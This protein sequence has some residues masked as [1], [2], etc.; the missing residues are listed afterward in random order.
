MI[1]SDRQDSK[2]VESCPH[3]R[4]RLG[5]AQ[6]SVARSTHSSSRGSLPR[7]R[8]A[9]QWGHDD[10]AVDTPR[11]A[12]DAPVCDIQQVPRCWAA[13]QAAVTGKPAAYIE[14]IDCTSLRW[15]ARHPA[16]RPDAHVSTNILEH[17]PSPRSSGAAGTRASLS[18]RTHHAVN[19]HA[20]AS[21]PQCHHKQ[22]GGGLSMQS[23]SLSPLPQAGCRS[24]QPAVRL[25]P[26][27]RRL[28]I[29]SRAAISV[30]SPS[31]GLL[32]SGGPFEQ[33]GCS[34]SSLRP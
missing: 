9:P 8:S 13:C 15:F 30:L 12:A 18:S 14:S 3:T 34:H 31:L 33:G 1:S 20:L 26:L 21:A 25:Q 19:A 6:G 7:V 2:R 17:Q 5:N 11:C 28:P 24:V 22:V 10:D 32:V 29:G 4:A 27:P 23:L 16:R